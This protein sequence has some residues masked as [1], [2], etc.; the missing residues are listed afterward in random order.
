M[1]ADATEIRILERLAHAEKIIELM[2]YIVW[3]KINYF[4]V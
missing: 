1:N 4:L 3:L 2:P